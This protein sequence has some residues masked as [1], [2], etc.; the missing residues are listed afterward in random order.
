MNDTTGIIF[1]IQRFSV[2]D[3]PGIRT[4]VFEKGC[5]LRCL[6][7][8]NP[9]SQI[10]NPQLA[11]T[12]SKCIGCGEC[13][14]SNL[15]CKPYFI[16]DELYWSDFDENQ[17]KEIL[18]ACPSKA[19]H[20]I[21]YEVK[22]SEVIE[23]IDRDGIFYGDEEGGLTI[24]GGEPLMQ[25]E[26]TYNLL[27]EA[28]KCGINTAIETTGYASEAVFTKVA[29]KL[30]YLIMDIKTMDDG[31]HRKV[32]GVSNEQILSNFIAIRDSYPELPIHIRTP[33]IP[34]VND[35]AGDVQKIAEFVKSQKNVR[36]ELLKYHRLGE[37]KYIS[38]HR[39]YP[40]GDVIISEDLFKSLKE[41][42]FNNLSDYPDDSELIKGAGI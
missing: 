9:E 33:I 21:G 30:D 20:T 19:L 16:E 18:R 41:F 3:G 42:E 15:Q 32:T 12:K 35:N 13:I 6:W 8:A 22:V 38:L 29:A 23:K 39:S 17:C 5:P 4:V 26:F 24:S 10:Q 28:Q 36:Y 40:M 37:N 31:V 1:N 34:G 14:K 11:W 7:C 2:H 25:D 27:N